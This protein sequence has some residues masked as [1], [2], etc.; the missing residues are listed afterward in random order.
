LMVD[1]ALC[2]LPLR[3]CDWKL[4]KPHIICPLY[5]ESFRSYTRCSY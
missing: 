4:R 3:Q 2:L 1:P 5:I